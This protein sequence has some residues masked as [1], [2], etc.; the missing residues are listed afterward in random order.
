MTKLL[1]LANGEILSCTATVQNISRDD[2]G[3]FCVLDQTVAHKKG[4]GQK[5]DQGDIGGV[6]FLDVALVD[7]EIRH[8]LAVLP[9]FAIG[10]QV[11][12][13]PDQAWRKRNSRYHSGGHAMAAIVDANYPELV[14][15]AGHHYKGE[16]RVEFNGTLTGDGATFIARIS[17]LLAEAVD[18]DLPIRIVGDPFA[19]RAIQIGDY[20]PVPCGGTH[21]ASTGQLG[22]L[23]IRSVKVKDGKTRVS[24]D[25]VEE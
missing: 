15:V 22:K 17:E 1:Y 5:G 18:A 8:Y 20:P 19:S 25:V 16:A 14:A 23:L 4:G 9:H 11:V 21:V 13:T 10:D 12:V 7:G 24:Y 3:P 2:R 6:Q